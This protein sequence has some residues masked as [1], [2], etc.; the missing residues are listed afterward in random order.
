MPPRRRAPSGLTADDLARL[1]SAVAG[2][3]RATVHLR[4]A[5]PGLGLPAGSSARVVSV[6][7]E[8]VTARPKGVEDALPFEAAELLA[9]KPRPEDD[10]P[11]PRRTRPGPRRAAPT[12]PVSTPPAAATPAAGPEAPA[13]AAPPAPPPIAP[14][15]RTT[16]APRARRPVEPLTVVLRGEP[17]A[18]WNLTLARGGGAPGP[19]VPVSPEA[20][21]EAVAALGH[22][23]ALKAADEVLAAARAAAARRVEELAAEL[24]AA[25]RALADLSGR[26]A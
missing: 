22:P 13:A 20:A 5:V 8:T 21:R 14:P 1:A 10:T 23:S 7:G 4:D 17:D 16:R 2:G 25:R 6:D 9:R 24:E 3:R 26:D 18:G 12:P 11:Q 15:R 19:A